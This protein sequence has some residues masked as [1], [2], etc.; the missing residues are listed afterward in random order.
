MKS[1]SLF[2]MDKVIRQAGAERVSEDASMKLRQILEDSGKEL[3]HRAKVYAQHA[4]RREITRD[5]IYLAAGFIGY[6]A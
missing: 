1:Y 2:D 3:L 6:E 5:D 4:G